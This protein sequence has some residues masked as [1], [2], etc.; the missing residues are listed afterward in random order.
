MKD[1]DRFSALR[2]RT[3]QI[4]ASLAATINAISDGMSYGWASP[5]VPVLKKPDTP[6]K[7][8]ESDVVWIESIYMIG[9]IV[10]LPVTIYCVDKFGR[11]LSIILAAVVNLIHWVLIATCNNVPQLYI[12]RLLTGLAGD[13]GFV[14][15][16]MY[17]AEIADQKIRG[18]LASVIYIMMLIG[19]LVVYAVAPFVSLPVSSAV[20]SISLIIQLFTLPFMPESPY[21]LFMKG[22]EEKA[23]KS[24]Q[25]LRN[26]K[27]VD[28]ELAEIKSAV[29]RQNEE[30][31]TIKDLFMVKSNRKAII[32]MTVLNGAQHFS[33]I[34]VMLMN[35]HTILA[36]AATIMKAE[37]AAI[38]FS[39]V[40][41]VAA[42]SASGFL[43]RLGRK[44]LLA[45]SSL[46]TGLSLASLATYF[47]MK[48]S[49]YD[50]TQFNWVPVASVMLYAVA[51]KLGLGLVP[52]V[53]T[54]ELF[55]T[56]VKAMGMTYSD[57][58]YV[59]FACI[60]IYL[61]QELTEAYGMH[62]PFFIF[63]ASCIGTA[64]FAL[65]YIPETKG[66]TLEEIQFILKGKSYVPPT[67]DSPLKE[68]A[69]MSDSFGMNHHSGS[70]RT[71][72]SSASSADST[73][74]L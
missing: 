40:M 24:L 28:K 51:F 18:L 65:W 11:K 68:T 7:I 25:F 16:P 5:V 41:V 56:N 14:S 74:H 44:I 61:Y 8:S 37:T 69:G 22:K 10:G 6:V 33:S 52:I 19:I 67:T 20:G 12:A 59:F 58:V 2:G 34:S 1:V 54:A 27:H 32:I 30:R 53:L 13:V 66:K 45:A 21:F 50:C 43:D 17:I 36:D 73:S 72:S 4:I 62:V 70:I 57:A 42:I 48:N 49:G 29:S 64:I 9:G 46:L 23:K 71:I 26:S 31:G 55:P 3:P 47:A 39:C 60:S 38:V 35:L 15:A 63:A